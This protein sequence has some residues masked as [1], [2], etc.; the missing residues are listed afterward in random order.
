MRILLR[1]RS[2]LIVLAV[3][4]LLYALLGFFILPYIVKYQVFPAVSGQLKRPVLAKEVAINPF[5]LSVTITGFE[6]QEADQTPLLGFDELFVNFEFSSLIHRAYRF[7]EIRLVMPF[8]SVRIMPSGM[9]NLLE[10]AQVSA[11]QTLR[12]RNYRR[13]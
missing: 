3:L 8:V 9:L 1:F 12:T 6:I 13:R 4:V 10:L 5:A 7:D 2:S 11:A